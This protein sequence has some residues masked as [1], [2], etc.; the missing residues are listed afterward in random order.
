V[1]QTLGNN[2]NTTW[3]D[4]ILAGD[5]RA[6]ARVISLLENQLSDG[7]QALKELYSQTGQAHII[8]LT[9]PPGA[10]KSSLVDGMI[11]EIRARGHKVAVIA[12]DPTSPFTGGAIL[13][14]RIRM[15]RWA[16]DPG[17]Y[18]RSMG[19]RGSLGG[20]ARAV[21]ASVQLLDAAGFPYILVETVGVGQSE[22][23]I[24]Q[25]ADTVVVV[26]VPGLGD[27]IQTSKAGI[28]EIGDVFT[29]NKAD[30][31]GSQRVVI[32][33][34]NML[35]LGSHGDWRPPV[36][37]TVATTGQGISELVTALENHLVSLKKNNLLIEKRTA[38]QKEAVLQR[39][40]E[41]IRRDVT[42]LWSSQHGN[43]VWDDLASKKVDPYTLE[44]QL[45][46]NWKGGKHI[47]NQH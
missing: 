46:F 15:Q 17:V 24:V 10:G 13:G 36:I 41:R 40:T 7:F 9:G 14:D 5:R 25:V 27:D 38:R 19:T 23:D 20:L 37:T 33:L 12:V 42:E 44:E 30:L 47:D 45:Y 16:S 11:K 21:Y 18:I 1:T 43:Q 39:L 3:S 22:V 32:E 6:L 31:P 34:Q 35:D 4:R 28:M 29:V 2:N 26:S 8:G